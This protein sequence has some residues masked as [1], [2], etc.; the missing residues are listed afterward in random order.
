M[1]VCR[2]FGGQRTIMPKKGK[3]WIEFKDHH[4]SLKLP[5]VNYADFETKHMDVNPNRR[6]IK[7]IIL[8]LPRKQGLRKDSEAATYWSFF[9]AYF[10]F[11]NQCPKLS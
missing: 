1:S 11:L 2:D 4:K 3:E 6:I 8:L 9:V 10:N 7:M 5:V